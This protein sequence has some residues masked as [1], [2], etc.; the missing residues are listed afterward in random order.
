M[1]RLFLAGFGSGLTV[2]LVYASMWGTQSCVSLSFVAGIGF[3]VAVEALTAWGLYA[4]AKHLGWLTVFHVE[5][6][7]PLD[8]PTD[9]SPY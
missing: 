4:L 2:A 8:G 7:Q 9:T 6:S 1:T 5:H 3:T